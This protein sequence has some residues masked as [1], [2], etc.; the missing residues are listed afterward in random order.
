MSYLP[1]G[2]VYGV[3]LNFRAEVEALAPQMDQPPYKAPPKAPVLYVKTANTW[4]PTGGAVP[5]PARVPEVEVGATVGLV[6]G[7][8]AA[9]LSEAEA[10]AAVGGMVLAADLSLPH[11][12]YY[13][14]AI[15]EK[16][17]DGAL[18]LGEIHPP[19]ELSRVELGVEIDGKAVDGWSLASLLRDPARLLA[20][21]TA[22]MTLRA[23]DVLLLG[24]RYDAPRAASGSRVRIVATGLGALEF[25]IAKEQA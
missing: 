17:F 5:V 2:T 8:D 7:R 14:P 18:P 16:C 13:R 21:V 6:L 9:R 20:N 10:L 19:G 25:E 15:R 23:G 11:S 1:S 22:F 12:S 3:L 4:T 24:V